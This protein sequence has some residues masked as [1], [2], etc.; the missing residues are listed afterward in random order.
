MQRA[1]LW[2]PADAR[3][4][5]FEQVRGCRHIHCEICL[6]GLILASLIGKSGKCEEP[7][8]AYYVRSRDRAGADSERTVFLGGGE[9]RDPWSWIALEEQRDAWVALKGAGRDAAVVETWRNNRDA[10]I[11]GLLRP[12]V[13][14]KGDARKVL[15]DVFTQAHFCVA[16]EE[17]SSCG[18]R[19]NPREGVRRFGIKNAR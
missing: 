11:V 13:A 1:A 6:P 12:G 17:A 15:L 4:T 19:F 18:A 7:L 2:K 5:C 10:A 3:R 14:S 9:K 16:K 8:A